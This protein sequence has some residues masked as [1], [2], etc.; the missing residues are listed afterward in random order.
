[1]ID[2]KLK[3]LRGLLQQVD[4]LRD[5]IWYELRREECGRHRVPVVTSLNL[6]GFRIRPCPKHSWERIGPHEYRCY[7]CGITGS[8]TA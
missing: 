1:M 6:E 3:R 7:V 8:L 5:E 4:L 2:E